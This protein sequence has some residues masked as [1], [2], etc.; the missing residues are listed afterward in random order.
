MAA[1]LNRE[2]APF[3]ILTGIEVDILPDGSLDQDEELLARLEGVVGSVRSLLRTPLELMTERLLTAVPNPHLDILGHC[4]GRL[5]TRRRDRPPSAFDAEHLFAECARLD[6]AIEVNSLP[7]RRDPL[8]ELIRLAVGLGCRFSIDS[9][10][11]AP[12]ALRGKAGA[13]ER[14]AASGA[15]AARVVNAL[16]VGGLL[17]W[18]EAHHL[19]SGA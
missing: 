8:S 1:A 6:K 5:Q 13:C 19:G 3:R 17:D 15:T 11:H 10:A 14:A 2:L 4:I 9:D 16:D 18:T 7:S 12:G